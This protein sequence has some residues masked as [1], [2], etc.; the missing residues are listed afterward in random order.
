MLSLIPLAIFTLINSKTASGQCK[1]TPLDAN[2]PSREEW[3][4]L[5]ASID[6]TLIRTAPA[7]SACYLGNPFDSDIPCN[8]TETGW[9]STDFHAEL[10]ASIDF[11]LFANNSCVPP[12]QQG[13]VNGSDCTLG[14][15]PTYVVN[16]TNGHAIAF[17]MQWAAKRNI[18]IVV[19]GTGHEYNGR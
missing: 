2:W 16:A 3:H 9:T 6:G 19:K 5:N 7:A 12:G 15:L 8:V 14:A 10:P 1:T 13:Y 18:R 11:P 4:A 17:A